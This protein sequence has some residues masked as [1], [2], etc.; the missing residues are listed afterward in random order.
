ML[1]EIALDF[2]EGGVSAWL[3]GDA[4]RLKGRGRKTLAIANVMPFAKD[5]DTHTHKSP[6]P[7]YILHVKSACIG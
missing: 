2:G 6:S 1:R 3:E 7:F 5:G 4:R